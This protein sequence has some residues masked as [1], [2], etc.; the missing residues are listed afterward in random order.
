[1]IEGARSAKS[2]GMTVAS[3]TGMSGGELS[4]IS[5]INIIIPSYTV[6]RIQEMH[7]TIGQMLCNALEI[8]LGLV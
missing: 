3:F 8:N 4:K 5:D 1:M 2:S 7:I 6:S